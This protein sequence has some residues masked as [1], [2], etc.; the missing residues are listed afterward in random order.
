MNTDVCLAFE[1]FAKKGEI[2]HTEN[3]Y[4]SEHTLKHLKFS[5]TEGSHR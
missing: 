1:T 5:V 2:V 4:E 3:K